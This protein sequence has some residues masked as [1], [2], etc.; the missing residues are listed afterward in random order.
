VQLVSSLTQKFIKVLKGRANIKL[1]RYKLYKN[2]RVL[3]IIHIQSSYTQ[4]RRRFFLKNRKREN[5]KSKKNGKAGKTGKKSGKR[6]NGKFF[7]KIYTLNFS[8]HYSTVPMSE[9]IR[10]SE[11]RERS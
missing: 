8:Q 11:W 3:H 7:K 10:A 2:S 1:Y 9:L 5:G 6:K 4:G